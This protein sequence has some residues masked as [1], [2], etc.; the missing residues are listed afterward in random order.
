MPNIKLNTIYI[1][2]IE[3]RQCHM[4]IH[5]YILFRNT[6]YPYIY[7]CFFQNTLTLSYNWFIKYQAFPPPIYIL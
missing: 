6:K 2:A 1:I 4:T 3:I 7:P 5:L